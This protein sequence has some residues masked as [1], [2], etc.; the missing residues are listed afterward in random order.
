M[1]NTPKVTLIMLCYNQ[2]SLIAESVLSLLQQDYPNLKIVISDDSSSDNTYNI[3]QS[4]IKD[5]K[6]KSEI[7]LN[8]NS[9]NLGIGR[10][11]AYVMDNLIEGD[12]VVAS[13]GDD[14]S[15]P[16]RVSRI[17]EEW[18][19]Q[20]KPSLVAH[21][22]TE[23]DEKGKLIVGERTIQYK[24]QDHS[25]HTNEL[26]ALQDYLKH[27]MPV[28][29]LGAAIAYSTNCYFKFGTPKAFPD[30]E[31]H[32]MYFRALLTNGVHYFPEALIKYRRHKNSFMS[33]PLKRQVALP[34]ELFKVLL[35]SKSRVRLEYASMY[36]IHQLTT[37]QWLD[38]TNAVKRESFPLD[39]QVVDGIWASLLNRHKLL[40]KNKGWRT[41]LYISLRKL[42][43]F[44]KPRRF[45][46][47]VYN[48]NYAK[49]LKAI[50]Y[51]AGGGGVNALSN[52][53]P[54]FDITAI[55]DS[56][57]K[58]HGD[59]IEGITI[60]SPQ[61]LRNR[62]NDIDCILITSG[63]FYAIK[64]YLVEELGIPEC[65]VIRLPSAVMIV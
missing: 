23:T 8:R 49:P 57:E 15:S 24:Y 6:G 53:G 16:N 52:I 14:I 29:Y 60:I 10:H 64:N 44:S 39:Y 25:I 35:N 1:I 9:R 12:L 21:S 30:Y 47:K 56:N 3:V 59:K 65:K 26:L 31:D 7:H 58:L 32:L 37:Q 46:A 11:F 18:L 33:A 38:Y 55:C 54:G 41:G 50:I 20:G 19:K 61:Q 4:L 51:G 5:Y 62:I 40:L 45:K 43:N 22:L 27:Q 48:L 28:R 34:S 17:V 36:R 42:L 63:Y 13:G 2:E